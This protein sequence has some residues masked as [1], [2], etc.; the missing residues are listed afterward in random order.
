MQPLKIEATRFIFLTLRLTLFLYPILNPILNPNLRVC[1]NVS[2]KML[3]LQRG[4]GLMTCPMA[5]TLVGEHRRPRE[6]V[7]EACRRGIVEELGTCAIR[8]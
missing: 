7:L 3:M 6:A 1:F 8:P 4:P 5:W 2:D